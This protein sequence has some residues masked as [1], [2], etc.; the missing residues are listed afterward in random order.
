VQCL[1]DEVTEDRREQQQSATKGVEIGLGMKKQIAAEGVAHHECVRTPKGRTQILRDEVD[2]FLKLKTLK[3][4]PGLAPHDIKP[5][6]EDCLAQPGSLFAS[7]AR[8]V[9]DKR[10]G[11]VC[12]TPIHGRFSQV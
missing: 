2:L 3:V 9:V 10:T 11:F 5:S 6:P 1:V 12:G 7:G 8:Q 4:A